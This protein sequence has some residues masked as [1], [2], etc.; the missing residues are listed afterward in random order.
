M[1][2]HRA[3]QR[4]DEGQESPP[5]ALAPIEANRAASLNTHD[6][7]FAMDLMGGDVTRYL[8][9]AGSTPKT[10]DSEP[11]NWTDRP[12]ARWIFWSRGATPRNRA[13]RVLAAAFNRYV[14]ESD[15]EFALVNI[16]DFWAETRPQNIPGTS[17]EYPNWRCKLAMTMRDIKKDEQIGATIEDLASGALRDKP[18]DSDRNQSSRVAI[19]ATDQV[20]VEPAAPGALPPLR[21]VPGTQEQR[22][23]RNPSP[24]VAP[25]ACSMFA[26]TALSLRLHRS[27]ARSL[28]SSLDRTSPVE[29][30]LVHLDVAEHVIGLAARVSV[31]RWSNARYTPP[32]GSRTPGVIRT[33]CSTGAHRPH[34]RAPRPFPRSP[35]GPARAMSDPHGPAGRTA[36]P[37]QLNRQFTQVAIAQVEPNKPRTA[38]SIDAASD[39]PPPSPPPT[40]IRLSS[41]GT[42]SALPL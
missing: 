19:A 6:P 40:G 16:E 36:H 35:P 8:G 12:R 25:M 39:E 13:H 20:A 5:P 2:L 29:A 11:A 42:G 41:S 21:R 22:R 4:T 28:N 30:E 37:N 18:L 33:T 7:P 32:V 10:L 1:P 14:A 31:I 26:M 17:N 27:A 3:V 9:K 15:A 38:T 34:R 23:T 24:A